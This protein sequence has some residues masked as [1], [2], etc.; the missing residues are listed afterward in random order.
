MLSMER[1][2]QKTHLELLNR[3]GILLFDSKL[4]VKR[5]Q[6]NLDFLKTWIL[7]QA[8]FQ[9]EFLEEY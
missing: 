3:K 5:L 4:K 2:L 7:M 9:V 1:K 8:A 6:S